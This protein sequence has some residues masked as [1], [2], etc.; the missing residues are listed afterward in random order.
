VSAPPRPPE[1]PPPEPGDEPTRVIP[2]EP[3]AWE[4]ERREE[5]VEEQAPVR[6]RFWDPY[7]PWLL[8]LLLLVLAG[9]GAL[10]YLARDEGQATV[11]NVV[12]DRVGQATARV[13]E[14]GLDWTVVRT[15]S[16][17]PPGT[18]SATRPGSGTEVDEGA[19]VTL[20][21][22]TGPRRVEVPDV[23]GLSLDDA[24]ARLQQSG[25]DA[26][27][28][29][30]FSDESPGSVVAQDPSAGDRAAAESAVRINVSKGTGRVNVPDVVGLTE[31]EATQRLDQAGLEAKSFEVPAADQAGTVVAQNPPAGDEAGKGDTV[32]INVSTGEEPGG[33]GTQ[34]DTTP[35]QSTG[36]SGGSATTVAVPSVVGRQL[37]AAQ[38]TLRAAGFT[39]LVDYVQSTQ[40][41]DRVVRQAPSSGTRVRRGATVRLSVSQGPSAGQL[42]SVPDV[43]GLTEDEATAELRSAGFRVRVF[44]ESTPDPDEEGL[45]IRQTPGA[46]R[47][48]PST[49]VVTIYVGESSG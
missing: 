39:A 4:H 22:S 32:R 24:R 3:P 35:T 48:V 19:E 40:P 12:G 8:L 6:R 23:V 5:A 21:V 33:T 44:T 31:D 41:A 28:R 47:R 42:R 11:P 29:R 38:R 34:T 15:A 37:E 49:A 30:V 1:D 45:V 25:L 13:E 9:L 10:W 36:G 26:R 17:R 7:W 14:A 20:V 46:G 2:G 16:A 43:V 18:V 27:V